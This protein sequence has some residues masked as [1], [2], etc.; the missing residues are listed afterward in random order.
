MTSDFV[1]G[2]T[3][4][5]VM[6][7][8]N[9]Q[10]EG[11]L[12][13]IASVNNALVKNGVLSIDDID[14]ALEKAEANVTSEERTFEDLSPANRDAICFPI[15]LLKAANLGQSEN[16]IQPFSELVRTVGKTKQPYGDQV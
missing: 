2:L 14:I 1:S 12:L 15:R 3:L 8:A 9:L 16:H 13:A 6:N 10:I 4:E 5:A 7:V 11:L